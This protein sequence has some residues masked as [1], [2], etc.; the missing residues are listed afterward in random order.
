MIPIKVITYSFP[1]TALQPIPGNDGSSMRPLQQQQYTATLLVGQYPHQICHQFIELEPGMTAS[2]S[3]TRTVIKETHITEDMASY[4]TQPGTQAEA[5]VYLLESGHIL[6]TQVLIKGIDGKQHNITL[7]NKYRSTID[8]EAGIVKGELK[9]S[10]GDTKIHAQVCGA[11]YQNVDDY[12]LYQ[13]LYP[14]PR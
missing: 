8:I 14:K 4:M 11:W 5:Y 6:P 1:S 7:T 3:Q 9:P 12:M 13:G 2:W 10:S